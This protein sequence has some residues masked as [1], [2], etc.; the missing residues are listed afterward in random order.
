MLPNQ[1][2]KAMAK[3]QWLLDKLRADHIGPK[4]PWGGR[5]AGAGR[6][7][8]RPIGTLVNIKLNN[9]QKLSLEEMGNGNVEDGIQALI[10]KYL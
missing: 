2:K 7:R 5:R 4:K 8:K 1:W 6:P 10:D 3:P 9:I